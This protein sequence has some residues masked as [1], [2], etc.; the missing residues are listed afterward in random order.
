MSNI[1]WDSVNKKTNV[2]CIAC[3]KDNFKAAQYNPAIIYLYLAAL[4]N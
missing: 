1:F 4:Y 2:V 3:D